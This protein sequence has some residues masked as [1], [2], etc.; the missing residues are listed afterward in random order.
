MTLVD[1]PRIVKAYLECGGGGTSLDC[2]GHVHWN[3]RPS[4]CQR[5]TAHSSV[6]SIMR[7]HSQQECATCWA[8]P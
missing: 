3:M 8:L 7:M 1:G 4:L 5:G 6:G 2:S